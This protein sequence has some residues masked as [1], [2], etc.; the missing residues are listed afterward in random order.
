MVKK[1]YFTNNLLALGLASAL[2]GCVGAGLECEKDSLCDL[3][4][5]AGT[6]VERVD[7]LRVGNIGDKAYSTGKHLVNRNLDAASTGFDGTNTYWDLLGLSGSQPLND[8][9]VITD[10]N[11]KSYG[12][13]QDVNDATISAGYRLLPVIGGGLAGLLGIL[14]LGAGVIGGAAAYRKK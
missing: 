11:G 7:D 2:S 12:L 1:D 10:I 6:A 8:Q 13:I 4:S 5:D 9:R 3:L 14:G